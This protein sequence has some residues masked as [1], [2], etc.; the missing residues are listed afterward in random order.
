MFVA[1]VPLKVAGR[2]VKPG[3]EV[4]EADGWRETVKRA[5]LNLGWIEEKKSQAVHNQPIGQGAATKDGTASA[6]PKK[7]RKSARKAQPKPATPQT[8]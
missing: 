6:K 4:P 8:N 2:R 5:H 1:C 7:R 3:E